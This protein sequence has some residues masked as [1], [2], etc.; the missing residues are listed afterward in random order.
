VFLFSLSV[1]SRYKELNWNSRIWLDWASKSLDSELAQGGIY[2]NVLLHVKIMI[3]S[4]KVSVDLAGHSCSSN[5]KDSKWTKSQE[6][7]SNFYFRWVGRADLPREKL[8][9]GQHKTNKLNLHTASRP[10][11]PYRACTIGFVTTQRVRLFPSSRVSHAFPWNSNAQPI[12]ACCASLSQITLVGG[13]A[14][15]TAPAMLPYAAF[16]SIRPQL[17]YDHESSNVGE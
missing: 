4:L 7:K 10:K 11:S 13:S 9:W 8:L 2:N 5:W 14:I 1:Y 17:E 6:I 15:S 16:N 3:T 12:N